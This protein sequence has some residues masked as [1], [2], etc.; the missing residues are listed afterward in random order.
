MDARE[1][2]RRYLEQRRELGESELVLDGLSVED[3]M[4]VLGAVHRRRAPTGGGRCSESGAAPGAAAEATR[5]RTSPRACCAR[6]AARLRRAAADAPRAPRAASRTPRR[7]HRTGRSCPADGIVVGTASAGPLRRRRS[8]RFKTLDEIAA[9]VAACTKCTLYKGATHPVPGE[10]N[11]D[12]GVHVRR[13]GARAPRKTRRDGRSWGRPASC[14]PRFSGAIDL[15]RED[16]FIGNV[17]KHRPPGESQPA[18]RRGRR[19]A[20]RTSSGRSSSSAQGHPGARHVRR[21]DAPRDEAHDRQAAGPGSPILRHA[22]DRHVSPRRAAPES[23][24][25]ASYLGRCPARPPNTRR[26]QRSWRDVFRDRRPPYSED[27]EAGGARPPCSST[28]TRSC[29]PLEHVDD[30]MFYARAA[31]PDLPRDGRPITQRATVVDPLTLADELGRARR[32]RGGGRQGVHRLPRRRRAD[33]GERRVPR[34]DRARE[35]AAPPPD[36]G[37]HRHRHRGVRRPAHGG[38][39]ARRRG[40]ADLPGQP[41]AAERRASPASRSCCGRRWSASRRS[42]AAA[43]RSPASP[44]ASPISTRSRR[45]SSP[46]T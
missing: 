20:A 15:K 23:L 43:R 28:R 27:A 5:R 8:R 4:R 46:P 2:L 38:R 1:Q 11:P 44:A 21:A 42:S 39:T 7:R 35:G 17:L 10:G 33:R 40:V 24:L 14:S 31:P 18:A 9:A 41:A 36:R 3:A 12:A 29:A 19:R 6:E 25:E 16:V 13:R 26:R 37:V 30:T 45:A 32:A 22:A 34:Q